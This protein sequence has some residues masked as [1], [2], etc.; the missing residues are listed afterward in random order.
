MS[1]NIPY[2]EDSQPFQAQ[3]PICPF[4]NDDHS[5]LN[6]C[7]TRDLKKKLLE[8]TLYSF[9]DA[10]ALS[11]EEADIFVTLKKMIRWL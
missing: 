10:M 7:D 5:S 9:V 3:A 8:E 6:A 2:V 1:S 4:C 11:K